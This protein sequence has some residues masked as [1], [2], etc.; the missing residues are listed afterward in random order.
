M[1]ET[2]E[3]LKTIMPLITFILGIFAAPLVEYLKDKMKAKRVK[4]T[5]GLEIEDEIINLSKHLV[6]VAK[7]LKDAIKLKNGELEVGSIGKY[8][9]RV[10]YMYFLGKAMDLSFGDF[11]EKQRNAMKSFFVQIDA[12][13][14]YIKTLKNTEVTSETLDKLIE[15]YKRYLYTGSC[16]LYTM[17]IIINKGNLK[18]C[19][20]DKDIINA[21]FNELQIE[22]SN[23]DIAIKK[24]LKFESVRG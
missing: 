7:A 20:N 9:P 18:K 17:R 19:E 8:T 3:S 24:I 2:S 23:D 21:V 12:T 1:T 5:L 13:N 22:F 6:K 16:M 15:S 11:D 4:K 10:I 14:E